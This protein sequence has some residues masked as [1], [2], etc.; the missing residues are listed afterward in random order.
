MKQINLET[1]TASLQPFIGYLTIPAKVITN[2]DNEA[3][4]GSIVQGGENIKLARL[5]RKLI[6][7]QV[8]NR[9]EISRKT[10]YAPTIGKPEN[11]HK[12][13]MNGA[14]KQAQC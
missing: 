2:Q 4:I 3:R 12:Q 11:I 13:T 10:L 14:S 6:T 5:R 8:A 9:A 7:Q 1:E